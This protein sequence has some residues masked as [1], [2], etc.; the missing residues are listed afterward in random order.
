VQ[1]VVPAGSTSL[2]G[3]RYKGFGNGAN[4]AVYAG[5]PDLGS[6]ANRNDGVPVP[7]YVF[8]P[9]TNAV[10]F[11]YAAGAG[12]AAASLT[13][14]SAT[15][16]AAPFALG[17]QPLRPFVNFLSIRLVVPNAAAGQLARFS[18]VTLTPTRGGAIS[19]GDFT[20]TSTSGDLTWVVVDDNPATPPALFAG[21][22]TVNG[23]LTLTNGTRAFGQCNENCK[24]ELT[25]GV[26]PAD[27]QAV[28][29]AP[30]TV[31]QGSTLTV[32]GTCTNLGAT[33]AGGVLAA[34][35]RIPTCALSGLPAGAT[36]SCSPAPPPALLEASQAIV[37]TSTFVAST[38]GALAITTTAGSETTDPVAGN[39][40]DAK[41]ITVESA[42]DVSVVKSAPARLS[43]RAACVCRHRCER[44]PVRGLGRQCRRLT[45]GRADGRDLDVHVVGR[46]HVPRLRIRDRRG[47][48]TSAPAKA[49]DAAQ[50]A[51]AQTTDAAQAECGPAAHRAR[52][53]LGLSER[54]RRRHGPCDDSRP[55]PRRG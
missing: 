42:P 53:G 8:T 20:T 15:S 33:A 16:V 34:P 38:P 50:A 19:L 6:A 28:T 49:A 25:A 47:A 48:D 43:R 39:N 5:R 14:T 35:A 24:L 26:L 46:K 9:S 23:T 32:T 31:A 54:P 52:E 51:D 29:T 4:R 18:N 13:N 37:C 45:A 55:E 1:T 36:Q 10:H 40:V 17:A 7:T 44:G 30:S 2:I 22:F 12:T 41:T 11:A 3:G 27:M 21:G